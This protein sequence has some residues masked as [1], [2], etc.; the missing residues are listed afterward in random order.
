MARGHTN[1]VPVRLVL[2]ASIL[3]FGGY[4]FYL[5][6][7]STSNTNK[8]IISENIKISESQSKDTNS[9]LS[10]T[11][12]DLSL[13]VPISPQVVDFNDENDDY[14]KSS[15]VVEDLE[16]EIKR[17]NKKL[18]ESQESS[19]ELEQ[20][21]AES[22]IKKKKME[23]EEI[24]KQQKEAEDFVETGETDYYEDRGDVFSKLEY[25]K[26]NAWDKSKWTFKQ[27]KE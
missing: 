22:E 8:V 17:L 21:V 20:Q 27:T 11:N 26:I 16:D 3:F 14:V 23:E 2:Y 10:L 12:S 24:L 19:E 13:S 15:D 4:L 25:K 7:A 9:D 1:V 6:F 5:T 18:E